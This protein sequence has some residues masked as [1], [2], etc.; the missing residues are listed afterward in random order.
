MFRVMLKDVT[1][2]YTGDVL[3]VR[4]A[5]IEVADKEFVVLVDCQV[6]A[7]PPSCA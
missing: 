3:A 7:N 1:K 5:T 2:I 6:A 4:D